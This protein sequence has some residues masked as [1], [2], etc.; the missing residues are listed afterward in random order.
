M[1]NTP[2]ELLV[3]EIALATAF[4][5]DDF[6]IDW[7]VAPKVK[8]DFDFFTY[9]ETSKRLFAPHCYL[10][11]NSQL[12]VCSVFAGEVRQKYGVAN[13]SKTVFSYDPAA[14][15]VQ[16]EDWPSKIP[17]EKLPLTG[18][19]IN[20]PERQVAYYFGPIPPT[21]QKQ[22]DTEIFRYNT[23]TGAVD[24]F[25]A[26]DKLWVAAAFVPVGAEGVIVLLGGT[27]SDGTT[28]VCFSTPMGDFI[29]LTINPAL[30]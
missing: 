3:G 15:T 9:S 8:Y 18:A 14:D 21:L 7:H 28:K 25:S 2:Y 5:T 23:S 12:I 29:A 11:P 17:E 26:P 4:S 24:R 27:E 6:K 16:I 20:V 22:F 10:P 13:T 1:I 19:F 30:V